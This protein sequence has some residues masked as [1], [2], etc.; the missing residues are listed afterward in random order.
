M[1]PA[2]R[3]V[4]GAAIG[5]SALARVLDA[6]YNTRTMSKAKTGPKHVKCAYCGREKVPVTKKGYMRPHVKTDGRRCMH[7]LIPSYAAIV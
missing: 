5:H 4:E 6:L 3:L 2:F 1:P 7:V